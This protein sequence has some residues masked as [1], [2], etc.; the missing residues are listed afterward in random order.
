[1]GHITLDNLQK[2][3]YKLN[4]TITE[5]GFIISAHKTKLVA[6]QGRNPFRSKFVIDNKIMEKVNSIKYI[7]NLIFYEKEIDIDKWNTYSRIPFIP[8]LVIRIANY[9]NRFG[10]S[11]KICREFYKNSLP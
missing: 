7:K 5:R 3:A 11:G 8:T 10:S 4:P 9:P 6:F 1:V 2:A